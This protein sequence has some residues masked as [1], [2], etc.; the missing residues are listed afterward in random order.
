LA[1]LATGAEMQG[2]GVPKKVTVTS[3]R[4][5]LHASAWI[6][7]NKQGALYEINTF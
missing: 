7:I 6:E 3:F 5:A 4:V 1:L 2:G